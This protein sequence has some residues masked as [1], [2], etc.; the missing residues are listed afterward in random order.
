MKTKIVK[1]KETTSTND[2]LR[3]E[4]HNYK[5][6]IVIATADY[7]SAGR[8]QGTNTWESE[9]GK[10]LL[11]SVLIHPDRVPIGRQFLLAMAGGIALQT[12][13]GTYTDG[14][15][16]KWPNDVYWHDRKLSGT[17]I[18]TTIAGG[19]I[20]DC[21]FGVGI[22]VNQTEFRSDASNPVSLCQIIGKEVDRKK[23]LKKIVKVFEE[24]Y[25]MIVGG[26]YNDIVALYHT[27]L[28]R[29]NGFYKYRD[30]EGEFEAAIVEVEDNGHLILRDHDGQMRE[31]AFKEVEFII[32]E[33]H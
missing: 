6:D 24:C 33:G 29:Q 2:F 32:N 28:Y 14:I 16:L 8:G 26:D 21:I 22:N 4:G 11:F 9:E 1:L 12:V 18:E 17:L 3:T 25:N 30:H 19:H 5:E 31:Y 20:N 15:T 10:N 7:Q 13:L 27:A 23:L